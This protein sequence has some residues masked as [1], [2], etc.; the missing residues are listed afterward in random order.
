MQKHLSIVDYNDARSEQANP[1]K[2]DFKPLS[3]RDKI[4]DK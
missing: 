1:G 2:S 3:F 4:G